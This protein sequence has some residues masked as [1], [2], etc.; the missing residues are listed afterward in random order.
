MRKPA[1]RAILSRRN[2]IF[3]MD[4]TL[5]VAVHDFDAIRRDLGL[6]EGAE[7][8]ET[9]AA[10][11]ESRS[12]PLHE[13]LDVIESGLTLLARPSTGAALLLERLGAHRIQVGIVTRNRVVHAWETLRVAGLQRF[14]RR[15]WI[16]GRDEAP[17]KPDPRGVRALLERWQSPAADSLVIGDYLFDLQ[18][19]RAAGTATVYVDES[20]E[21]PHREHA[22][23]CVRALSDL[24]DS[25]EPTVGARP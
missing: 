9:L 4:G 14:F 11:P 5:T 7:I 23:L 20:G 8:L 1:E 21:F 24:R 13:K 19:G 6:P 3:D 18:A 17:P 25:L 2:W 16:I 15:E 12:R 22:D 10:M